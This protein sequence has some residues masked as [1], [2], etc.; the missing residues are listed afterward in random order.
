M[1]TAVKGQ[2]FHPFLMPCHMPDNFPITS[3][4]RNV[5]SRELLLLVSQREREIECL[6]KVLG[7]KGGKAYREAF[8]SFFKKGHRNEMHNAE[9]FL[10]FHNITN[11]DRCIGTVG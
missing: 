7:S 2:S 8:V 10:V 6:A 9:I 4:D 5:R 11:A 3:G 1:A